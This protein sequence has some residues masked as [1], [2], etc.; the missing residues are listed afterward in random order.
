MPET[1]IHDDSPLGRKRRRHRVEMEPSATTPAPRDEEVLKEI[2]AEP[3]DYIDDER[4]HE[5]GA[6]KE[7][8]VDSPDIPAPNTSWYQPVLKDVSSTRKLNDVVNVVL[9]PEQE[10]AVFL[11]YNYARYRVARRQRK[12][13]D[14]PLS[15]AD[16]RELLKWYNLAMQ[17]RDQIAECNLALVLAMAKRVRHS[18]LDFSDLISE[19]NMALLRSIDKFDVARGFKFSTYACRSILKA[20]SRAGVKDSKYRQLFPTDFDPALERSDHQRKKF[21]QHEDECAEEVRRIVSHNRA[22]LSDLEQVVI[23]HRFAMNDGG[24]RSPMTLEQ[25]GQVVGLTKERVRQI[26]NKAL[27]KIRRTLE[28]SFL[29]GRPEAGNGDDRAGRM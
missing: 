5:R 7:L 19:G 29:D 28:D 8:F 12:V 18:E 16:A 9:K 24:T 27:Q 13:G 6:E 25:V 14:Q 21:D 26:Q 23:D 17:L 11:Q 22:E 3:M 10:R 20:F 4:F 2:L 15:E 1:L